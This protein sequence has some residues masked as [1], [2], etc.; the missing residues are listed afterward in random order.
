MKVFMARI[1][2]E[3]FTFSFCLCIWLY[4]E[5]GK[6]VVLLSCNHALAFHSL[7]VSS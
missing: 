4:L 7:L 3:K 2:T 1:S 6:E 5:G